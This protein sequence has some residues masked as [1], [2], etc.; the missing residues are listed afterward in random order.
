MTTPKQEDPEP[1]ADG[2]PKASVV[3]EEGCSQLVEGEGHKPSNAKVV[4]L[5][6]A[7]G[8]EEK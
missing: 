2:N 1:V 7:D 4:E 5:A 8:L 6:S 3:G